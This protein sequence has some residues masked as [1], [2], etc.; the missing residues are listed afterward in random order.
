MPDSRPNFE[1]FPYSAKS[2]LR[3]ETQVTF[4]N[5]DEIIDYTLRVY[6]ESLEYNNGKPA[7]AI[8]DTYAQIPFFCNI[9]IFLSNKFQ[10]DLQRYM[11][12]QDTGTPPYKGDYGS[13]PRIW[14]D[15]YHLIK[16]IL[17][18]YNNREIKKRGKSK[19]NNRISS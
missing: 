3:G 18:T 8:L 9:N 7:G 16:G 15:K 10:H 12:A 5:K 1:A 19:T 13:I 14:I 17:T 2:V 11:Y 6:Y 4:N